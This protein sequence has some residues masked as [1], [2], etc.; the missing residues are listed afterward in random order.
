MSYIYD[1]VLNFQ[2][3]F[4]EF[5]EWRREDKVYNVRKIPLYHISE[6][7]L[8]YF[9][10]YDVVVDNNFFEKVKSDMGNNKKIMCLVSDGN[11]GMG[12]LFNEQGRIIKRS[13]MLYD[14]EDEVCSY[15]V[16]F[17]IVGIDYER[18]KKIPKEVELRFCKQ[19]RKF[20]INYLNKIDDDMMWKYIYYECFGNDESDFEKIKKTLLDVANNVYSDINKKLYESITSISKIL[21]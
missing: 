17:D 18:K 14:E 10:Y 12:L 7:D 8:E 11:V 1:I 5:F 13:S 16:E 3:S 2:K 15:A 9:K 4:C 20:L 19:R 21:N 6:K